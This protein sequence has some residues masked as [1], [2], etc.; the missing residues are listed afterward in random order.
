MHLLLLS[1]SVTLA[2]YSTAA[3]AFSVEPNKS[4]SINQNNN[5]VSVS[6]TKN[7]PDISP[8]KAHETWLDF[9]WNRG[10][11]LPILCIG[12][13]KE[14][15]RTL[16]PLFAEEKLLE[17]TVSSVDENTI[18]NSGY[19]T[20]NQ[21]YI[22]TTLGPIWNSEIEKGSHLGR[23]SFSPYR[24]ETL[25][26][27]GTVV[28][29]DVAYTTL[30]RNSLWQSVTESSIS[31]AC[32]NLKAYLSKPILFTLKT[33]IQTDLSTDV[34]SERWMDFI[35]RKGG[36][37]PIPFPPLPLSKDGYDRVVIPPFLRERV[38]QRMTTGDSSDILY[39]VVNPSLIS[40]YTH[41]GRVTFQQGYNP[42]GT[43]DNVEM[44]WQVNLRPM[45]G[46]ES[47]VK[48]FTRTVIAVLTRNFKVHIEDNGID[49]MVGVYPPRGFMKEKGA[50]FQVRRSTW[51]GSVL[52]AHLGDDRQVI[53]QTKDLFQPWKWG[54][55]EDEGIA[56]WSQEEMILNG[57]DTE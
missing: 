48:I 25:N 18:E 50:I 35:W 16:L 10:G 40:V 3:L 54:S 31:D 28:K 52:H 27:I 30:N 39:T 19:S 8:N 6:I 5:R 34:I 22:L 57:T 21:E 23:V 15:T 11:G 14:Q 45:R 4:S 42:T 38:L 7:I 53:E 24:N 56:H 55:T 1:I 46:C 44:V 13:E 43:G 17:K 51:V 2:L 12:N 9:T 29:W 20:V 37:L 49:T 41:L 32:D 26:E 36:G 47:F 33:V